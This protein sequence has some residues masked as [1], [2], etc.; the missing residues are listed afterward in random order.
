MQQPDAPT[1]EVA[2][3]IGGW[4][5]GPALDVPRRELVRDMASNRIGEV[6]ERRRIGLVERV[7]LRP[8]GGGLEWDV[9]ADQVQPVSSSEQQ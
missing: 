8:R 7:W 1:T 6:M 5:S 4:I 3:D 2:L 9:P